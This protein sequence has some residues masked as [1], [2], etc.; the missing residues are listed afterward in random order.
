MAQVVIIVSV[1]L[2]PLNALVYGDSVL[3]IVE[4]RWHG[5]VVACSKY[6]LLALYKHLQQCFYHNFLFW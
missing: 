1:C 6:T 2:V 3:S 5:K 4:G